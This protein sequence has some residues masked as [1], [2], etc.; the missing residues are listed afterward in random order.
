MKVYRGRG[1]MINTL[2]GEIDR[3]NSLGEI[4][5]AKLAETEGMLKETQADLKVTEECW[6]DCRKVK[7]AMWTKQYDRAERYLACFVITLL[8]LCAVTGWSTY[9][10][11][12]R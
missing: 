3:L 2:R 1:G 12:P 7:G 6:D 5:E 8:V 11:F 10:L 4:S 9:I